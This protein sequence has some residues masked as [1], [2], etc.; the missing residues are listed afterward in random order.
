MTQSDTGGPQRSERLTDVLGIGVLTRLFQRDLVDEVIA[1]CGRTETRVR[2]LPARVVLYYVL[3]LAL[4]YGDA[5]EEVMRRLTHGLQRLGNWDD[6][7]TVPSS[8][9]ISQARTRLG[10]QPLQELFER[11]AVPCA[12]PGTRGAWYRG[13]RIMAIDGVVLDAPD[14]PANADAFFRTRNDLKTSPFPQVRV[15]ALAECGTHAI[16]GAAISQGRQEERA[17][18]RT[19]IADMTEEMLIL[20]DSGFYS[21]DLWNEVRDC[22]AQ[23]LWRV[24]SR[25]ELPVYEHLPDGSYLSAVAPKSWHGR[26]RQGKVSAQ[27]LARASRPMRVIEYEVADRDQKTSIRLIT[28]LTDHTETPALD[29]AELYHQRWE[30]ENVFDEIET[31]QMGRPR[32]LRS[33]TPDLVYQEIWAFLLTHYAIRAFMREAADDIDDDP[34]RLSFVRSLR[35]IRRQVT[36]QAGF[37]PSHPAHRNPRHTD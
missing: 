4:F 16:V 35:V 11:T 10:Y 7:W 20:A 22:G 3:A 14:T 26:A 23:L 37:S 34:D 21:Y 29:L 19:V 5:Y 28:S 12:R 32:V 17:L 9:A 18:T 27:S 2:L 36:D 6:R 15:L 25:L 24:S 1:S 30:I 31:H 13:Y 33:R 8:S